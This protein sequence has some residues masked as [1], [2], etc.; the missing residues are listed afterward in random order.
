[1]HDSGSLS[2][3][4]T[5]DP[6]R[7]RSLVVALP[8][9]A[10]LG[11]AQM[12]GASPS[13]APAAP[14]APPASAPPSA[15]PPAAESD[16]TPSPAGVAT[17]P[18]PNV[19]LSSSLLFEIVAAEIAQ[20]RGDAG[21]A[22][23]TMLKAARETRDPRLARRA[24]EIALSARANGQALEAAQLWHELAP[25]SGEAEQT[26]AAL[27]VGAARFDDA[28]PLLTAQIHDAPTPIEELARVQRL[29]ARM[30]D[31]ARSFALLQQLAQPYLADPATAFDAHL[32]VANGAHAAGDMDRAT[33]EAD[34]AAKLRPDSERAAMTAA[35][36]RL[37]GEGAEGAAA[38]K[39]SLQLLDRFLN[40]HP[41]ARDVRAMYARLLVADGKIDAARHEFEVLLQGDQ[42]QPDT[43]YALGLLALQADRRAEARSYLQRYVDVAQREGAERDPD[44]AYLE[45]ARIAVDDGK[46]DEALHWLDRIEGG[47]QAFNARLERAQV[48]A[49]MNRVDDAVK[50]L[51][52]PPPAT[53]EERVKLALA[54]GQLLRDAH[55]YQEWYD[56]LEHALGASPDDSE[57]LYETAMAAER[58]DRIDTMEVYLRRLMKL[59]PD[60]A[61]A[62]NALGYSLADRNLRLPEAL[63]LINQALKLAPDDA[64][65]ID[66]LGWVQYRMGQLAQ[67]RDTLQHA[68]ELKPEADVAAHLGEVLWQLGEKD[69]AR[70]VWREGNRKEGDNETLKAT[71]LRLKVRL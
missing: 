63:D 16:A 19:D 62:Y 69:S 1:M 24:T 3:A 35:Q 67:A 6:I 48:L 30:P 41:Q 50:V 20:Q 26:V 49:R 40:G 66:S 15:A 25:H 59:H 68:Y 11:C 4:A 23:A 70:R 61:H 14:A 47:E 60:Y 10:I 18:L 27:L 51:T 58:L 55:R 31:R 28:A 53:D 71:L 21:A 12:R 57:L 43:L 32:V 38:R 54:Q 13:A 34:E 5:R 39:Q 65:I 44:P 36:F 17:D 9:V 37:R 52:D 56:L 7:L 64:F 46:Y 8:L 45:L 33:S 2:P 42:Q 22:F 29:L